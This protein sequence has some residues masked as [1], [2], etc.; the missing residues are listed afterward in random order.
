MVRGREDVRSDNE[1]REPGHLTTWVGYKQPAEY[2]DPSRSQAPTVWSR[3]LTGMNLNPAHPRH[4]WG[5]LF[6]HLMSCRNMVR[7]YA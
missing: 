7:I 3:H 2:A 1:K 6:M 4:S 5:R